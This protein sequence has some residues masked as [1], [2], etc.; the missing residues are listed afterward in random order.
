M[1]VSKQL[2]D[3]RTVAIL[4]GTIAY[5]ERGSGQPLVFVHGV[6]VNGDLWRSVAPVLAQDHRCV[7]PDL[8]LGAHSHPLRTDADMSLPGL[9]RIVADLVDALELDDVVVVAN[10]TGGAV[11]QWLVGHHAD[12]IAGLILTPCDAFEKFPP[13]PQLYLEPAARVPALLWCVAK[14]VQLRPSELRSPMAGPPASRS[15]HTSCV[16]TRSRSARTR[17]CVA[18]CGGCSSPSTR[19]TRTR[20]PRPCADSTSRPSSYGPPTT[21]FSRSSTAGGSPTCS[22]RD[23]SRRSKTAGRSSPRTSLRAWW[24]RRAAS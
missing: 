24:P 6:R 7:V 2:G 14:A 15:T 12:R 23:A 18:T 8:P 11:A 17:A 22:L 9:A 20:P 3:Q 4:T 21:S 13:T 16:R 10:D 1:A 19:A 5:R